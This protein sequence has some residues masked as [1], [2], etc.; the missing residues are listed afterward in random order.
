MENDDEMI[1]IIMIQKVITVIVN[2]IMMIIIILNINS[3][4]IIMQ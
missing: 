1:A 3:V 2:A 4:M